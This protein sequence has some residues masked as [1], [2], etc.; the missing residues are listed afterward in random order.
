MGSQLVTKDITD[1][2]KWDELSKKCAETLAII[3][4]YKK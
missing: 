4:K 1:N 3:K 2:G